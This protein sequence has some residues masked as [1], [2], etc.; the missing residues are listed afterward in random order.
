MKK[1]TEDYEISDQVKTWAEQQKKLM[2]LRSPTGMAVALEGYLQAKKA[3]RL[4]L[5][6]GNGTSIS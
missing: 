5:T 4:D 1:A 6:L 3:K 2:D